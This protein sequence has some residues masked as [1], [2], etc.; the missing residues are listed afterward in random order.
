MIRAGAM[1]PVSLS[2]VPGLHIAGTCP[3]SGDGTRYYSAHSVTWLESA[4]P[5][6]APMQVLRL[7]V[8]G[9]PSARRGLQ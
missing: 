1:E 6:V 9:V 8:I 3:V 5:A 2:S 4:H 7:A